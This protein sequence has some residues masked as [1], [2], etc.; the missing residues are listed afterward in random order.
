MRFF[1]TLLY[2]GFIF[3][4][5]A[6][7]EMIR[8]NA[9][10]IVNAKKDKTESSS[11]IEISSSDIP[12]NK[13]QENNP[14][15]SVVIEDVA[16]NNDNNKKESPS[17]NF[18]DGFANIV[19]GAMHSVVNVATV[20]LVQESQ[21]I[22]MGDMFKGSPFEDMFKEF[23]GGAFG[24]GDQKPK[25]VHALGSGF[26]VKIDH[27][28]NRAYI[29]T[30][31]HV[32]EKAKKIVVF[33]SDKTELQAELHAY[34][35]RTD[36]AVLSVDTK[37][38]GKDI[39]KLTAIKWGNSELL[40][41]GNWVIA[42]GNPFGLGSTVT[43]GIVSGK[44]RSIGMPGGKSSLSFVDN[45]IQHSAPINMG[46]S[47]GCL[48]NIKGEVIGINNAIFSTSGGNIGIGFA[49]PS[50]IAELTVNQ[51]IEHKRTFRGWF[52]AEIQIVDAKQ[53][54]SVGIPTN[55]TLD[56]SKVFGA[57]VSKVVPNGPAD[58]A[59]IKSGDIILSFAGENISEKNSLPKIVGNSKIDSIQKAVVWR[60]K[61]D[62]KW[63]R[64]GID[65]KVGDFEKALDSG[66]I[67]ENSS[68]S[69]KN[70]SNNKSELS[71]DDLGIS[72]S[73]ITPDMYKSV[74]EE[75]RDYVVITKVNDSIST[76]FM[77]SMF[78]PGDIIIK[79]DGIKITSPEILKNIIDNLKKS[80]NKNRPISFFISREGSLRIIATNIDF[81]DKAD[82]KTKK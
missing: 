72:I 65:V 19:K 37:I 24:N 78:L 57:F 68:S 17:L 82:E 46:N 13:T 54:E 58:K 1:K 49:I 34:D 27:K 3:G 28:N 79:A 5:I 61:D 81:Q 15:K 62:G 69:D 9:L 11:S 80:D 33:L 21:G 22:E 60:Q 74:P 50:S 75:L 63:H 4:I 64:V 39:S 12:D 59:G 31:N 73:K 16:K 36:I 67:D 8:D 20:Q 6:G 76:T 47:G 51:L 18:E 38:L 66:S 10:P 40:E 23:F 56:T 48:L 77:E 70:N 45:F 32:V 30:N 2:G 43:Q 52:G 7:W 42:I 29:V 41:E 53:A 25:K 44:G 26:I 55:N 35:S 71:I 14:Q